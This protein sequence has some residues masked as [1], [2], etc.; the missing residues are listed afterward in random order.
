MRSPHRHIADRHDP[1]LLEARLFTLFMLLLSLDEDVSWHGEAA[2]D[3]AREQLV[4]VARLKLEGYTNKEIA[5]H[6]GVVESTVE[7]KL[8]LIHNQWTND[9]SGLRTEL[10]HPVRAP[11]SPRRESLEVAPH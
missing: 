10:F 11:S 3:D 6:L 5:D 4:A 2:T 1:N 9:E 7:R 8:R